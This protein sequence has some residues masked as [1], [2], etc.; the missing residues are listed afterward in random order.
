[1]KKRGVINVPLMIILILGVILIISM[2]FL[3]YPNISKLFQ[4]NNF[5]PQEPSQSTPVNHPLHPAPQ[6]YAL[7]SDFFKNDPIAISIINGGS[8]NLSDTNL[9]I[10]LGNENFL[11]FEFK[12]LNAF[13]Q[14]GYTQLNYRKNPYFLPLHKFE[15]KNN[16]PNSSKILDGRVLALIDTQLFNI[17]NRDDADSS[18][19]PPLAKFIESPTNEP[20]NEHLAALYYRFYQALPQNIPNREDM[21]RTIDEFRIA[22]MGMGGNLGSMLDASGTRIL[23]F[24]EML[25]TID[26]KTDFRFCASA[27][28]FAFDLNRGNCINP[29]TNLNNVYGIESDHYYF[30]TYAHEF[31]HGAGR[32]MVTINGVTDLIYY[33]FSRISF[34]GNFSCVFESCPPNSIYWLRQNNY[35]EFVTSYARNGYL[36]TSYAQRTLSPSEDFA[37]SFAFYLFQ[38]NVFREMAKDNIYLQQKYDFLKNH[39][40]EGIEY[41]TGNLDFYNSLVSQNSNATGDQIYQQIRN[42]LKTDDIGFWDGTF[43]TL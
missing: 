39:V 28:Y 15:G 19:Y 36:G 31:G 18:K 30:Y 4:Q 24:P 7:V 27:Y 13:K 9:Y 17:E 34:G 12:L 2:V 43:P 10:T 23:S 21:A 32:W 22:L 11:S 37:E 25:D 20:P 6:G 42:Y 33:Q 35:G 5:L 38:G 14:I 29:P 1:M 41:N 3:F 40:F 8:Y 16:L 26:N